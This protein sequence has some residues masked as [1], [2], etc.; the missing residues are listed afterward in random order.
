[1]MCTH[2]SHFV[3]G[4]LKS[5]LPICSD[6]FLIVYLVCMCVIGFPLVCMELALGQYTSNNVIAVFEKMV[7]GFGGLF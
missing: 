5:V 6:N 7:P 2:T 3:C 1:M 4:Y